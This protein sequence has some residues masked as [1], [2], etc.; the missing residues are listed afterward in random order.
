MKLSVWKPNIIRNLRR[1]NRI[2]S[3]FSKIDEKLVKKKHEQFCIT[4]VEFMMAAYSDL[5]I[6][7]LMP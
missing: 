5:C 4:E 6:I 3:Y 1:V 7:L 2:C